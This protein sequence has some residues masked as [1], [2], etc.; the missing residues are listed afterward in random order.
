MNGS[1]TAV[2][3][4]AV[5][6]VASV[7]AMLI[8]LFSGVALYV[9]P[10]CRVAEIT[11]WSFLGVSKESWETVHVVFAVLL[12][13]CALVHLVLNWTAFAKYAVNT[14]GGSARPR[15]LF[16]L[17]GVIALLF[18]LSAVYRVPPAV[19]VHDVHERIKSS[20]SG[21]FSPGFGRGAG[22]RSGAA[23]RPGRR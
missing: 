6:S 14:S 11:G 5:F 18:F 21:E 8:L 23:D 3:M 13:V 2:R 19:W 16:L 7:F 20:Y 17:I 1:N 9:A 4:R 15:G 10:S 22:A 12:V